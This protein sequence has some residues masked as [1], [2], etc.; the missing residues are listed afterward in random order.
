[1]FHRFN[2]ALLARLCGQL[3]LVISL[4][5]AAALAVSLLMADGAAMVLA[6]SLALTMLAGLLLR[7]V[8]GRKARF[9]LFGRESLWLTSMLWIV[10]PLFGALPY[11]FYGTT[12]GV[13]DAIFE[14]V[15]GFTTT[16]AS[17]VQH[18]E[19]LPASLLLWRSATQWLGGLGLVLFVVAANRRMAVGSLQLYDAEFSGTQQRKLHPRIAKSVGRMWR[20]YTAITLIMVAAMR[21]CGCGWVD[22]FCLSMST[23]STG[24]FVTHCTGLSVLNPSAMAVV[25]VFMFMSGLNVAML[26]N[27]LTLRW[28]QLKHSE[29]FTVYVV[30]FAV[31]VGVCTL[32]F[33]LAGNG[34]G[35]SAQYSIFH[36]ASTLST[37]GFYVA[38]PQYWSLPV[39]VFTFLLMFVGAM[40]GSTGGGLKILRLMYLLRYLRNYITRMLHPNVVFSV[41]VDSRTIAA[42]YVNKIFAFV[43]LYIIFVIAGGFVL[44][45]CGSTIPEALSMA[46]ANMANLGPSPLMDS[47]GSMPVYHS[48]PAVAKCVLMLLMLAGRLEIF[49]L[50]AIASPLI[51]HLNR[52]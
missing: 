36:I 47:T 32:S 44:T 37:S 43:F 40:A 31:S 4:L 20:I 24:G 29:E 13:I 19:E 49:A 30:L 39:S 50:L 8:F 3:L 9:E 1:M 10:V 18:P 7:F 34:V 41:K 16:G 46:A 42:H 15:S 17:V 12:H 14:S 27:L 5:M 23:V 38:H 28:R 2:I 6:K 11:W 45:L 51:T 21:T 33:V 52:R 22:S 48:L 35:E 26:Y 25:V